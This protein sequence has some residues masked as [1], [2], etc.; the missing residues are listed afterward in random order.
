[1]PLGRRQ[2]P[3]EVAPTGRRAWIATGS[4]LVFAA[5]VAVMLLRRGPDRLAEMRALQ[6]AAMAA[7]TAPAADLGRIVRSAD[8]M[9]RDELRVVRNDLVADWRQRYRE[10]L[11]RYLAAPAADKPALLDEQIDR[12]AAMIALLDALNPTANPGRAPRLP[13]PDGDT[14]PTAAA[15]QQ[16]LAT[17]ANQ[18]R[19]RLPTFR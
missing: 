12:M 13:R 6:R 7:G 11:E 5:A 19:V 4:A 14:G 18:R 10:C 17:R 16:A 15:Y 8:R 9:S 1:M 3:R 2:P